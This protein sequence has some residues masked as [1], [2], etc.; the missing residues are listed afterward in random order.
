MVAEKYFSWFYF[1][2]KYCRFSFFAY[3]LILL[4]D[5]SLQFLQYLFYLCQI[6][7]AMSPLSNNSLFINYNRNPMLEYFE[8]GLC[9]TLST[10]DPNAIPF[11]KGF[12][13]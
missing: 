7:I 13:L 2:E 9:V 10:D 3:Y 12:I 1:Y 8:R 5:S 11:Y 6:G 4:I